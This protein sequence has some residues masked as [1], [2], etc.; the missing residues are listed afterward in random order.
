M[1]RIYEGGKADNRY[2]QTDK[3][4]S[5]APVTAVSSAKEIQGYANA[6]EQ[7]ALTMG[8]EL[9]RQQKAENAALDAQQATAR[10]Q[11][12]VDQTRE[13]G[14]LRLRQG[15]ASA[16]A[17]LDTIAL[18][19]KADELAA[20]QSVAN[21]KTDLI[22]KTIS[23]LLEFGGSYLSYQG[24]MNTIREQEKVKQEKATLASDLYSSFL[25]DGEGKL[26]VSQERQEE[27]QIRDQITT[28]NAQANLQAADE[29]IDS[30]DP[31]EAAAGLKL[32]QSTIW[33]QLSG[34]RGRMYD[35]RTQYPVVLQQAVN[36][37]L[38]RPTALG[39]TEDLK[40]FNQKFLEATGLLGAGIDKARLA[41]IV[42]TPSLA[43]AAN[44]LSKID[45][46]YRAGV[47]AANQVESKSRISSLA[48][49]SNTSNVGQQ[50]E[51]AQLE[52]AQTQLGFR[53]GGKVNRR[54]TAYNIAV[55][56]E[57][58][59]NEGKIDEIN[60][61]R[62]HA[63]NPATPNITL[64]STYK[65]LFDSAERGA[66]TNT[67][68]YNDT[69]S[70]QLQLRKRELNE[71]YLQ[72]PTNED[73]RNR[74]L[75]HLT[76]PGASLKDLEEYNTFVQR[77]SKVAASL[78]LQWTENAQLG[79]FPSK[80]ELQEAR[81][82]GLSADDYR[83]WKD[84]TKEAI[85]EQVL[86]PATKGLTS[87]IRQRMAKDKSNLSLETLSQLNPRVNIAEAKI[88]EILG[89][90]VMNDENL[91]TDSTRLGELVEQV[92]NDVLSQPEFQASYD[93]STNKFVFANKLFINAVPKFQGKDD[94]TNFSADRLF[95]P[96]SNLERIPDIMMNP[97]SDLFINKGTLEE[98]AK[99]ILSG[100]MSG[101]SERTRKI[102]K[103]LNLSPHGLIDAQLQAHGVGGLGEYKTLLETGS[104]Y[105]S[106][107]NLPDIPTPAE[108]QQMYPSL[109][110]S[111]APINTPAGNGKNKTIQVGRQL[112]A[113][114]YV[115]WQHPN[116]SID[117]GYVPDGGQ[118]VMR[119]SYNSPHHH[120]EALDLPLSHNSEAR[121]DALARR[122][123]ANPER[124]GVTQVLWKSK[125]HHDH[126][127]ITFAP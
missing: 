56:L 78:N 12:A 105:E 101:V 126:L 26:S 100:D 113:E 39:G 53:N 31:V 75:A 36:E 10:S 44:T 108:L 59:K 81:L 88:K 20:Q 43:T 50:F 63:P 99:S 79:F 45:S 41:Q 124:Y 125:G 47:I 4:V 48:S 87:S 18:G 23:S 40:A 89:I 35:A 2:R 62:N 94:F 121:L 110:S 37:G 57:T 80:A 122:L 7:D 98:E 127:H 97:R 11:Q 91:R 14:E 120:G 114:G 66:L 3:S 46:D 60:E 96:K 86:A 73:A 51:Q 13:T 76:R 9:A 82:N 69:N 42:L 24:S 5:Y 117:L 68:G 17:D 74:Y 64:G 123:R 102:A 15:F 84:H 71:A 29:L 93:R 70:L 106:P 92:T 52:T 16:Q 104:N 111:L 27:T 72:D 90:R 25:P 119:R 109:Q 55:F 103:N 19:L 95:D 1:A 21:A 115:I 58:L 6:V 49:G 38:I 22:N 107:T 34:V 118:R 77:G 85:E 30:N 61:L 116:F 83:Y 65:T 54:T 28:A 33:Q 112:L 8:R 67:I 32:S